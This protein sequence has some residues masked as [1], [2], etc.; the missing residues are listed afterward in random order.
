MFMVRVRVRVE[1]RVRVRVSVRV[2]ARAR[3]RARVRARARAR[4]RARVRIDVRVRVQVRVRV[5]TR[6]RIRVNAQLAHRTHGAHSKRVQS[7]WCARA[8]PHPGTAHRTQRAHPG[9]ASARTPREGGSAVFPPHAPVRHAP[10]VWTRRIRA[11]RRAGCTRGRTTTCSGL[12][13][14]SGLGLAVE[15]QGLARLPET[16]VRTSASSRVKPA[17]NFQSMRER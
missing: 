4:V 17:V 10:R 6:F 2:R 13:L 5:R 16:R 12:G 1:V 7:A 11:S 14:G 9:R 15:V 8:H 3:A